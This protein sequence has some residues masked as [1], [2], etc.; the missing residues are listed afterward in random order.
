MIKM[1]L[2]AENMQNLI[3]MRVKKW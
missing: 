2:K 1:L 3:E